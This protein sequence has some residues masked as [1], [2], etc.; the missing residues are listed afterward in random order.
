M[1]ID[2]MY[3]PFEHDTTSLPFWIVGHTLNGTKVESLN[4]TC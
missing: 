2:I 3:C 4:T 1:F